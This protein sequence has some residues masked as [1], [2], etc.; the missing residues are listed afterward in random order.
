MKLQNRIHLF[1]TALFF[2]LLILINMAI[3]FSFSRILISSELEDTEEEAERIIEEINRGTNDVP[4]TDF[5]RAYVPVNGMVQVINEEG[6]VEA[7]IAATGKQR[8]QELPENYFSGE[9]TEVLEY[10]ENQHTFVSTPIIQEDGGVAALQVTEEIASTQEN[11]QTLKFVLIAATIIGMIPLFLS[12]R[13]LSNLIIRPIT[14]MTRTMQEIRKSGNFKRIDLSNKSRD[15]LHTMGQSFND[16]IELLEENYK[17]QERFVSNASHELKT[18]LTV[19]ESY[20]SLLKRRGL[21][22]PDIFQ[23]S[24]EAINSEAERMKELTEQLLMLAKKDAQWNVNMEKVSLNQLV[25]TSVQAFVNAYDRNVD[26]Q[27]D[28]EVNVTT[29]EQKLKQLLYIFMDNA[30]KYSEDKITVRITAMDSFGVLEIID[31][32][33]G[34]SKEDLERVFDRFYRVDEARNR[35]SGGFGLGL[36]LAKELEQALKAEVFLSSELGSGTKAM[37]K[38]PLSH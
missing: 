34:I 22:D 21:S 36:S 12:S 10:N 33:I 20:S 30:K 31:Y 27:A 28:Q 35:K 7:G 29:D 2:V 13:L 37:I 32:G 16:M 1:T 3:Y 14:S 38:V 24:V 4:L 25:K 15:E 6:G 26:I 17:K 5:L 11:L 9:I 23:E 19:V 18:P 8:L